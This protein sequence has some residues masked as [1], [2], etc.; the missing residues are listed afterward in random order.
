MPDGGLAIIDDTTTVSC[1]LTT[2]QNLNG[3]GFYSVRLNNVTPGLYNTSREFIQKYCVNS[4]DFIPII[5]FDHLVYNYDRNNG[6][7]LFDLKY[8]KLYIIDNSHCFY[9]GSIWDSIQL[10]KCIENE[11]FKHCKILENNK[12]FYNNLISIYDLERNKLYEKANLFK[13][14][15]KN[16]FLDEIFTKIPCEWGIESND[17]ETLKKYLKYRLSN[18]TQMCDIIFDYWEVI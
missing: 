9:L 2:L 16:E 14:I 15:I 17:L 8:K 3:I 10:E 11:D 7:A 18:L 5:L 12:Y 1:Q 4:E 13:S 6:N